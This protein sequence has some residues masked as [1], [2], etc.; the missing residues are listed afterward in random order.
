MPCDSDVLTG[1]K[2]INQTPLPP[3]ARRRGVGPD[4]VLTDRVAAESVFY[5]LVQHTPETPGARAFDWPPAALSNG[6]PTP[7]KGGKAAVINC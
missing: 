1:W 4:P 2:A 3:P 5:P 6:E 7:A